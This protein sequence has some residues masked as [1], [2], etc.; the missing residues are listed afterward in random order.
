[1]IKKCDELNGADKC[2]NTLNK[3]KPMNPDEKD[4]MKNKFAKNIDKVKNGSK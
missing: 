4:K 2:V 1:V 3:K